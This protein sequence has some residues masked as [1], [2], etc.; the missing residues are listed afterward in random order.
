MNLTLIVRVLSALVF[1]GFG[2]ASLVSPA[3]E[4]EFER[5]GLPQM[6]VLTGVL[7]IAGGLGLVLGPTPRW[8]AAAASGLSALMLGALVVRV[9]IEDP[10]YAMLPAGG[11][12]VANAWLAVRVWL[13]S[14]GANDG[15]PE[16][17]Q[18]S[19]HMNGER[20]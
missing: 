1:L 16:K 9:H 12:M 20:R 15:Q 6:R 14:A 13:H 18:T 5:Y 8:V 10:W 3:V 2:V 19:D 17:V 4:L 11:L 7:E